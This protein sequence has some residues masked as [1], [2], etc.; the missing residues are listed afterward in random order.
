MAL[1]LRLGRMLVV[2]SFGHVLAAAIFF[3]GFVLRMFRA[4][5]LGLRIRRGRSLSGHGRSHQQ[6]HH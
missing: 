4:S 2:R 3:H 5:H 1:M 6:C